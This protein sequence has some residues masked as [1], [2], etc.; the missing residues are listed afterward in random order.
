MYLHVACMFNTPMT[1]KW[2][3]VIEFQISSSLVTQ[4]FTVF[5]TFFFC[6][7]YLTIYDFFSFCGSFSLL[8]LPFCLK[9][10]GVFS[11]LYSRDAIDIHFFINI[12]EILAVLWC[13]FSCDLRMNQFLHGPRKY[14]QFS[15]F[16]DHVVS[17]YRI[18]FWSVTARSCTSSPSHSQQVEEQ[19]PKPVGWTM[20]FLLI[21]LVPVQ[22]LCVNNIYMYVHSLYELCH[23]TYIYTTGVSFSIGRSCTPSSSIGLYFWGVRG[24]WAECH[25]LFSLV[26]QLCL[27]LWY[28]SNTRMLVA[29]GICCKQHFVTGYLM[30]YN[31]SPPTMF[32]SLDLH[33]EYRIQHCANGPL[34]V[35]STQLGYSAGEFQ[36]LQLI[37]LAAFWCRRLTTCL[38]HVGPPFGNRI[39]NN[40]WAVDLT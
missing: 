23:R 32:L 39:L 8:T 24:S 17:D 26:Y 40:S 36:A 4:T 33:W 7:Q 6:L 14:E 12:C 28:K 9:L 2:Q 37:V 10:A 31:P 16:S 34:Y 20:C 13:Y 21:T 3:Y 11:L 5:T 30:F 18:Q 15:R 27:A 29:F 35:T 1:W 22:K 38:L 25:F 19:A